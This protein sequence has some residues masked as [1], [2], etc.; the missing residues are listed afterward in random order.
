[1]AIVQPLAPD[2]VDYTHTCTSAANLKAMDANVFF[3]SIRSETFIFIN[4]TVVSV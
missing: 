1:L 4:H 3:I 2:G